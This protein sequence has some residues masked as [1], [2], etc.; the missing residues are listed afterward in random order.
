MLQGTNNTFADLFSCSIGCNHDIKVTI[1][2][3]QGKKANITL[4]DFVT[5][6]TGRDH[7]AFVISVMLQDKYNASRILLPVL[8]FVTMTL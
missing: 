1:A 5:C 3:L 7:D 4:A 8:P 6:A 2:T